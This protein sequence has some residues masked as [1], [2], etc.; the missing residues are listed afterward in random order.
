MKLN[1]A[2]VVAVLPFLAQASPVAVAEAQPA[3]DA[4]PIALPEANSNS[5]YKRDKWCWVSMMDGPV[6][7]RYGPGTQYDIATEIKSSNSLF[8]V[9]CKKNG[10]IVNGDP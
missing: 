9:N 2:L 5:L 1:L 3:A 10:K 8:G 4:N 7:C 6:K